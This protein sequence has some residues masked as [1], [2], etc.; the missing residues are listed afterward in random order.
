[1]SHDSISV[2][3]GLYSIHFKVQPVIFT[4]Y[5]GFL[6]K[7][8]ERHFHDIAGIVLRLVLDIQNLIWSLR[9]KLHFSF[10]SIFIYKGKNWTID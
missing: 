3:D 6:Y 7:H 4:E 1:L 10:T 9:L 8:T 2:P 5:S